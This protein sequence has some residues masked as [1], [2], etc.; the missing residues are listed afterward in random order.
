MTPMPTITG[1][2]LT[3]SPP[4]TYATQH[5]LYDANPHAYW[6]WAGEEFNGH[7][8]V[9]NCGGSPTFNRYMDFVHL[10]ALRP[11]LKQS[12]GKR[13]LDLG[14]GVGRW[15]LRFAEQGARVTGVDWSHSM[16]R[17]GRQ[18]A[19]AKNLHARFEHMALTD[20]QFPD[21]HYDLVTCVIVLLHLKSDTD[22]HTAIQEMIRVVKPGG[23]IV[24]LDELPKTPAPPGQITVHRHI[25][26]YRQAVE[27]A[28]G[29]IESVRFASVAPYR[30]LFGRLDRSQLH[31]LAKRMLAIPLAVALW[32]IDAT[33]IKWTTIPERY[34]MEDKIVLV[35]K[36]REDGHATSQ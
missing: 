11:F 14:C 34:W 6:E 35:R 4:D 10:R 36:P 31:P 25:S 3:H 13:V 32:G 17:A 19:Q 33:F 26:A 27:K 2:A 9:L 21:N 12:R 20:L 29:T 24:I 28:G 7:S 18:A 22:F 15:T 1:N 8:A 23:A 16:L 5:D 30:Q